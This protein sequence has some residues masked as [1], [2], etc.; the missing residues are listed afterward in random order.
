MIIF[1]NI[2]I[3]CV[4]LSGSI[5]GQTSGLDTNIVS[6]DYAVAEVHNSGLKEIA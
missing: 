5:L 2:S 4:K 1:S 6:P 3:S